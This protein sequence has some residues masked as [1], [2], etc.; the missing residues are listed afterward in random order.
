M[1]QC[2]QCNI[3]LEKAIVAGVEVDYC[4]RC[5]GL[6]FEDTEL[7]EAK[8]AKDKDLRWLDIDLWK[9]PAQFQVSKG[10]RLCP[11][12]HMPLY[13]V[14]YGD[15]NIRVDVCNVCHGVWLDR[16]EF[17]EI[18]EYLKE[19]GEYEVMRHYIE[20][21]LG[22]LWEVFSGPEMLRDEAADFLTILK[23]LKYKFAAQHPVITQ[24]LLSLPR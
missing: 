24:I 5:Y 8:D 19:K 7:R 23:L 22:E 15:S 2:P 1:K 17:I 21:L 3:G 14:R 4:K 13:E 6:W 11:T 20:N 16:G 18:I 10:K 12:D 9:N